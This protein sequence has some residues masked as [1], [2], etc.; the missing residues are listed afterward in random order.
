M[1]GIELTRSAS[2]NS[3]VWLPMD[4]IAVI[5]PNA[6]FDGRIVGTEIALNNNGSIRV[7][8]EYA[9]VKEMLEDL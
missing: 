7:Q 3:P 4:S 8:E 2:P 1:K 9:I 6:G 5:W